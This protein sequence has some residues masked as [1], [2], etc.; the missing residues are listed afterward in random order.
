MNSTLRLLLP[1]GG[2]VVLT[3]VLTVTLLLVSKKESV[4]PTSNI[5][6]S[7]PA[8]VKTLGVTPTLQSAPCLPTSEQFTTLRECTSQN[9]C[10]TCTETPTACVTVEQPVTVTVALPPSDLECSGHGTRNEA[11]QCV[12]DGD[13]SGDSCEF[14][15]FTV[16]TAG[17]YCLPAYLG[18]CDPFT[19]DTV[20]SVDALG[21]TTWTCRCKQSMAGVFTQTVEGGNCDLQVACG[22]PVGVQAYVNVGSLEHP[23]FE[24]GTVYPN[25]LTSYTDQVYGSEP[26]VYKTIQTPEGVVPHPEADPT[27]VPRVYSNKCT[28]ASGGGNA[29]VIRG[30]GMPGDPELTRV[31][32][33][34]Y[35]PVPPKLNTCPDGWTGSGTVSDPCT[36]GT[37]TLSIFTESGEWL[38]PITSVSELRTWWETQSNS[39]WWGV[40]SVPISDVNCLETIFEQGSVATADS[41]E[42]LFCVDAD[43]T[44]ARGF[45]KRAWDGA[46][47]GPLVDENGKPHWV[48]GGE[49]GGQCT[50]DSSQV[51]SSAQSTD[52]PDTW[53]VCESDMCSTLP[54]SSFNETTGRCEC[55]STSTEFPY[56]TNMSYKHPNVPATCVADPCNPMGVNVNAAEVECTTESDCGGI[57]HDKQCY[58]PSGTLCRSDLDCSNQLVGFSQNVAKCVNIDDA[59]LGTCVT[60]DIQRARMGSTCTTDAN[61]SLGAC[62][63]EEGAKTCTGGC[64]C[65]SGYRQVSDGGMSPLGATCVDDCAGKC[66]NG[67]IC[68]HTD[69][70]AVCRCPPYYGGET[71]ETSLCAREHE[72]CDATMPC[73][74]ACP[75][76]NDADAD[77]CCNR[78]PLENGALMCLN[79]VCK[80]DPASQDFLAEACKTDGVCNPAS[81][82]TDTPADCNGWGYKENGECVCL[83]TRTGDECEVAVCAGVNEACAT[84]HDCCNACKCPVDEKSCCPLF[85]AHWLPQTCVAGVCTEMD[86]PEIIDTCKIN[87]VCS[88]EYLLSGI[89]F[90]M[91]APPG[92]SWDVRTGNVTGATI[93]VDG[94]MIRMSVNK[95]YNEIG[96]MVQLE[97]VGDTRVE[98]TLRTGTWSGTA[99]DDDL[100]LDGFVASFDMDGILDVDKSVIRSTQQTITDPQEAGTYITLN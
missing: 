72:Y 3:I 64:A 37:D 57:C 60:L 32:P 26:C 36:D 4:K 13:F 16:D 2:F 6:P 45:R 48:T 73:C 7:P 89:S 91:Q 74:S 40:N 87:S 58:I 98:V 47:D 59:G 25:R 34:F 21:R 78:F 66:K 71:C 24:M 10:S 77:E 15:E 88:R 80:K 82:Y 63:G 17:Q 12:C 79:N 67:G 1:I 62:V 90:S 99:F 46:T 9:D 70:G 85:D 96:H 49:Y 39:A 27:C 35:T 65:S 81:W 5:I 50:C 8:K 41:P 28:V 83:P 31:S 76:D 69:T 23:E 95:V 29:Q 11:G 68:E 97:Q 44:A 14:G 52:T 19:S 92:W 22:A 20:L 42:S 18:K 30:S 43:C 100:Y 33:P 84:D 38:G 53:W 93:Y 61:C 94:D 51:R 56:A 86:T 55:T 75:C 54:G